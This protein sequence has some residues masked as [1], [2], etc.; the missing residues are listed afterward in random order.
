M[1]I[2]VLKDIL[3]SNESRA[4]EIRA[5][6]KEKKIYM[7]DLMSSPGSGK[8]TLLDRIIGSLKNRYR[9]AVIE[10]DIKTTKDAERLSGHDVPIIQIETSLFGGDCHLESSWIRK[11]LD[12]FD[13]DALDLVIIE[14]IGNLVCPAEFE[15]GDDERIVVLSVTEGEDKPVKYPLMFNSSHTLLLNKVDL[16]PHLDYSVDEVMANIGRVNPKMTVFRTSARTGEGIDEFVA[17]LAVNIEKK[18]LR[19]H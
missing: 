13:L 4:E 6:L 18:K 10:G 19:L 1:E 5:L 7:I 12:G 3:A 8:T 9:I 2:K 11:C 15:L 16:L 17:H 14:N